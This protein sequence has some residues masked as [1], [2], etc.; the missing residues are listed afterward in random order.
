MPADPF[1]PTPQQQDSSPVVLAPFS[2]LHSTRIPPRSTAAGLLY[3]QH[4]A[5]AAWSML[6]TLLP[7]AFLG[8]Y[9]DSDI[10]TD[11][12]TVLPGLTAALTRQNIAALVPLPFEELDENDDSLMGY[13]GAEVYGGADGEEYGGGCEDYGGEDGD[14]TLVDGSIEIAADLTLKPE[15]GKGVDEGTQTDASPFL[16]SIA[17][18]TSPLLP[19]PTATRGAPAMAL[20]LLSASSSIICKSGRPLG[21]L[22]TRRTHSK[23]RRAQEYICV[24]VSNVSADFGQEHR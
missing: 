19:P 10:G 5:Q 1:V 21:H 16:L 20:P 23:S 17:V 11:R 6:T 2:S 24:M 18:Q 22:V 12:T 4:Q 3:G 15:Q 8:L 7:L 9:S 13:G 14:T